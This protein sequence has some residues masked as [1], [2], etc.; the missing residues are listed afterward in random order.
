MI[1]ESPS[2]VSVVI[3]TYNRKGMVCRA[4]ESVLGQTLRSSEII[5]VDDGSTD[6][7]EGALRAY[8]NKINYVY[9]RNEGVSA[10]RNCGLKASRGQLVAFLDSDDVWLPRMLQVQVPALDRHPSAIAAAA[11]CVIR[12]KSGDSD[13]FL[14]QG[15]KGKQEEILL[16]GVLGTVYQPVTSGILI[17]RSALE[18]TGGFDVHVREYEDLDL[19]SR[20]SLVGDWVYCRERLWIHHRE[21]LNEDNVSQKYSLRPV[22]AYRSIFQ[23][24]ERLLGVKRRTLGDT[25]RLKNEI[26]NY[27]CL[28][29]ALTIDKGDS[30]GTGEVIRSMADWPSPRRLARAAAV[31]AG[32]RP[33]VIRQFSQRLRAERK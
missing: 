10:A 9:Q 19:W 24:H 18:S 28:M 8:G 6:G 3:P 1:S 31:M 20:L 13:L 2:E 16:G 5:V 29:G 14:V 21:V 27:R 17:R 15:V 25:I 26:G 7:T 12:T 30:G 32:W 23:A 11:N 22:E 4:I 33:G